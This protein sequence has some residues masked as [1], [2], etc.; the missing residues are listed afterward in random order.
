MAVT[1]KSQNSSKKIVG[2]SVS[3]ACEEFCASAFERTDGPWILTAPDGLTGEEFDLAASHGLY[4]NT[5]SEFM[6]FDDNKVRY[7]LLPPEFLEGVAKVLTVGAAKYAP[8]NWRKNTELWRYEAAMMR[9][10][11]AYRSGE[12]LDPETG[13]PHLHHAATNLAFLS[14]LTG[15]TTPSQD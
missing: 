12:Y 11:E 13:L 15:Q 10:F 1:I 6:K 2:V 8:N 9:H 7:D 3:D 4:V 14:V 5:S